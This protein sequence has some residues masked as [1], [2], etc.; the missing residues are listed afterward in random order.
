[1]KYE[2]IM[3]VSESKQSSSMPKN[4]SLSSIEDRSMSW[5]DFSGISDVKQVV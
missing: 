3:N 1:M 5:I 2:D 4:K